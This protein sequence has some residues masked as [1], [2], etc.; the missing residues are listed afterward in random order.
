ML[1]ALDAM[2]VLYASGDDVAELLIPFVH[3]KG[4]QITPDEVERE[5]LA[6]SLGRIDAATFWQRVG[7][8][9]TV[10]DEYLRG[11]R[12]VPGVLDLLDSA[13]RVFEGVCCISNDVSRWSEKLRRS[14]LLDQAIHPWIIS[15]DVGV[16]KPSVGIYDCLLKKVDACPDSVVLVDDRP[17]NL[18]TARA[19]GMRTVLFD[20]GGKICG[21]D[22]RRV[23]QLSEIL[24]LPA[25]WA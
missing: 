10:E 20:P 11:H 9:S 1:L 4:S 8:D 24:H 5:Y 17:K 25:E 14:F 13:R 3:S 16:R 18:D 22:H 2:G 6:A 19:A 21:G 15:A 7:L 12:L 23:R